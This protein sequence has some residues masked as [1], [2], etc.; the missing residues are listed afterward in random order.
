MNPP[1][2]PETAPFR[3]EHIAALNGVMAGTSAEQ[4]IWLSGFLAGYQA[5]TTAQP[6]IA[7]SPAAKT[8]LA[9]VYATESGN[10]ESLADHARKAAGRLGFAAKLHDAAELTPAD[11]AGLGNVLLIAST[12][13][14]GDAPQRAVPFYT[15]LL[16]P[17]AP[18]LEG[19]RYGVLALGD[20]AY[21]N[22]CE[23][24]RRID[25]RLVELG[26]TRVAERVECDLDYQAVARTWIGGALEALRPA[27]DPAGDESSGAVIHVDFGRTD[28][29]DEY[30][31]AN[32]FSAEITELV[33]LN[34]S[35]SGKQTFHVELSLAGSGIAY[36][37]GDA[38]GIAP[39]NDKAE[40]EALLRAAGIAGDA[41]LERTLVEKHDISTLTPA[42]V[43]SY[44]ELTGDANL[45]GLAADA[46]RLV[47]FR[48]GRQVID[49]LETYPHTLTPA[50]LTGLLRPLP[51]R[52]YS[53]A[54]S[55]K[56][57]EEEAHL[58]VG[59]VA[60]QTHARARTGVTSGFL[61][62]RRKRG[63]PLRVH[64]RANKHFRL[65]AD[66]AAPIIMIGPGTGVAPFRAF[67]QEREAVDASGKNWL[68]FGD[69]NFTHD[70]L[71][72][73]EW[74]DYLASGRLTH[75]DLAFSRDQP[76]KRYVQ[77]VL[78]QRRTE[79]HAWLQDGA[80]LYICGDQ[81]SMA[82]DVHMALRRII[83][84]QQGKDEAHAEAYLAE[85]KRTGRY[86]LDVY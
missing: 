63:D 19:L 3:S 9:I 36:E 79:L 17:A 81:T 8:K 45:R 41:A 38:I 80:H 25:E 14:E 56:A 30:D 26:A 78:W 69:R 72:Q 15:A 59:L 10:S 57:V 74:L 34:S 68:F 67:L 75:L 32:P 37:P 16:D 86:L 11:L 70:F 76:A 42:L 50:Q 85:L 33:N 12:W 82:G 27:E 6:A 4:R 64:L 13:G 71:Y 53:V 29:E 52:L 47:E 46:A 77:H 65:P 24:G 55:R 43:R 60:Y 18:R 20:Q 54:S 35:R 44:A 48:D 39:E 73:L 40:V 1:L 58:L 66:P 49:L 31:A 28:A 22:F 5:A 83:S 51:A 62:A 7:A 21:I 84:D 2:L 61:S 23:V